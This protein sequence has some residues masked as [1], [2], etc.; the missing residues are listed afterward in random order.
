[1]EFSSQVTS[2]VA[3]GV[4]PDNRALGKRLGA[5]RKVVAESLVKLS[6][7]QVMTLRSAGSIEV[8]NEL[9]SIDEV[10]IVTSF[11]GDND[12]FLSQSAGDIVVVISRHPDGRFHLF[13]VFKLV[14]FC[15]PLTVFRLLYDCRFTN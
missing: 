15:G 2:F 12:Q 3:L 6:H 13:I 4:E 1:L 14:K 8:K 9:I 11:I 5:K 7:D 10:N